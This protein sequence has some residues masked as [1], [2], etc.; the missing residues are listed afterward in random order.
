[1]R[2]RSTLP[3]VPGFGSPATGRNFQK[4]ALYG[5]NNHPYGVGSIRNFHLTRLIFGNFY[6]LLEIRKLAS[7]EGSS[8]FACS[9][10]YFASAAI[11]KSK[12]AIETNID[13]PGDRSKFLKRGKWFSAS[14]RW[15]PMSVWFCN[16]FSWRSEIN[17]GFN[18]FVDSDL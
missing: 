2:K 15:P 17:F 12:G 7:K 10:D 1:M 5:V 13:L 8:A 4:Y 18:R 3:W 11:R 14:I 9:V 6:L 16:L